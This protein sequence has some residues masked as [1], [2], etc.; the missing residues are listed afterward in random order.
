MPYSAVLETAALP[1]TED[2]VRAARALVNKER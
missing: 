2:L 1:Q